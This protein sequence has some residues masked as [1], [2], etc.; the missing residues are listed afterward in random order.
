[1]S[2]K[3][4]NGKKVTLLQNPGVAAHVMEIGDEHL[5]H[6]RLDHMGNVAWLYPTQEGL[7]AVEKNEFDELEGLFQAFDAAEGGE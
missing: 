6:V 7:L 2:T 3:I 5:F 1:M 4:V